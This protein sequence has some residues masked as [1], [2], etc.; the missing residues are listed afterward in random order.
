MI[1][2]LPPACLAHRALAIID[3]LSLRME[4]QSWCVDD[5]NAVCIV[6]LFDDLAGQ[7][8]RQLLRGNPS[9]WLVASSLWSLRGLLADHRDVVSSEGKR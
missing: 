9:P 7:L 3:R 1:P 2:D 5:H 4:S 6:G 8:E